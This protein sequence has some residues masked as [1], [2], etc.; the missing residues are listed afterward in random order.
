[1][2]QKYNVGFLEGDIVREVITVSASSKKKAYVIAEEIYRSLN[3]QFRYTDM[4][5]DLLKG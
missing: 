5:A 3:W 4:F 2:K 1:M